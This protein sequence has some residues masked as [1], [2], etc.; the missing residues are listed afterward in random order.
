VAVDPIRTLRLAVGEEV[1]AS[2]GSQART[3]FSASAN[4]APFPDGTLQFVFG[5]N[6]AMRA[7]VFGSE[8]STMAGIRWN[9]SQRS[10]VNVSYQ[11][12][13]SELLSTTSDSRIFSA[14]VRVFF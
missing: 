7:Q 5:Y 14:S 9:L 2:S 6:E 10:Y 8:R 1:F 4:W 13:K 12:L 3:T 11:S